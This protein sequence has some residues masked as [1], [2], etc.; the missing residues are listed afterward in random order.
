MDTSIGIDTCQVPT[1]WVIVIRGFAGQISGPVSFPVYVV[2]L[3]Y[4]V[5]RVL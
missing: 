4:V 5:Y 3:V 1:R 2:F